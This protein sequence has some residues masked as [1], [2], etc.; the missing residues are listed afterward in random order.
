MI[1]RTVGLLGRVAGVAVVVVAVAG[2]GVAWRL[3]QGPLSLDGLTPYVE[4]ALA[5]VVPGARVEIG[6]LGLD[7][8]DD[9]DN[10][11]GRLDVRARSVR[12]VDERG[13][14]LA[15]VPELG[16]GVSVRAL[17]R[18]RLEPTRLE[19]VRP[20]IG[21][22]RRAD[23]G[24]DLGVR[25]D[26]A[27]SEATPE[28][29]SAF[30]EEVLATLLDPPDA[31]RPLGLLRQLSV[32]GADLRVINQVTGFSWHATRADIDLRRSGRGVDAALRLALDTGGEPAALAAT[33]AFDRA[34]GRTAATVRVEDLEPARLARIAPE[35]APLAGA[36]FAVDGTVDLDLD[37]TLTPQRVHFELTGGAGQVTL[38]PAAGGET[39]VV[40]S[41][42]ARGS[43]DVAARRLEIETA[44]LHLDRP[45]D[46]AGTRLTLTG[47][48]ALDGVAE[49]AVPTGSLRLGLGSGPGSAAL[50][51]DAVRG[52]ADGVDLAI[53]L[54]GLKPA[55]LAGLVPEL[56]PLAAAGMPPVSGT[57]ALRL[58]GGLRPRDG[59]VDLTLGAGR[60]VLPDHFA[61]PPE[62]RSGV[63]RLAFDAAAR[64]LDLEEATL[65]LGGP[66]VTAH[67]RA[68]P[69]APG[70]A[71][72]AVQGTVTAQA[73]PLDDLG[74]LWPAGVGA[75]AREW[76]TENLSRGT[77]HEAQAVIAGT[78]PADDPAGFVLDSLNAGLTASD[79]DIAYFRPMPPVVG[80]AEVRAESDGR[81]FTV[82]TRGG[83]LEDVEVGEG[84]IVIN[85]LGGRE[86]IDIRVPVS[87]PV[88]TILTVLDGPPLGYPS[89]LDID[90]AG[91]AG[92]ARADLTF[93]FPLLQD[94]TFDDVEVGVDAKLTGTA[95]RKVAAGLDASDGTLDLVLDTRS[96]SV[97]GKAR[98][99]GV[100]VVLDWKEQFEDTAK[101]PRTRVHVRGTADATDFAKFGVEAAEY[102]AGPVGTDVVFTID[103]NKRFSLTGTLDLTPA[104]LVL[105]DFGWSKAPGVPASARF[106]LEFRKDKVARVTGIAYEGG[107][108]SAT[109]TVTLDPDTAALT[110]VLLEEVRLDETA[111]RADVLVRDGG[112]V[113]TVTGRS[114]DAR[115]F[116]EDEPA[117]APGAAAGGA[118]APPRRRRSLDLSVRVGRVV[119]GEGRQLTDVVAKARNDGLDWTLIDAT[120]S[121]GPSSTLSI[122]FEPDGDRFRVL[123]LSN[124]AGRA[125]RMLD[126]NDRVEGGTLRITGTTRGPRADAPI[127]GR[128]EMTDYTVVEAPTL[129]RILNAVSP[130][131]FAELMQG[132]GIT[133]GRLEGEFRKQGRLL[134]LSGVRTSGSALGLTLEGEVDTVADVANLRGTIVPVYGLNRIVGQI[135]ILGDVL[136]GGAGQGIF[137]A[138][139]HVQGPFADPKVSVNPLAVLAPGFLRNLFF[140]GQGGD[141]EPAGPRRP[142]SES[143]RN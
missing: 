15:A 13:A 41:S 84:T 139:W 60:L 79:V 51:M 104:V 67:G 70:G 36:A 46:G 42:G 85:N 66:S 21:V 31:G 112:Y 12:A 80:V 40:R 143:N 117:A 121:S 76:I 8:V 115:R 27:A 91:T 137:A 58:D 6:S 10:G 136:S 95:V 92:H 129:A 126:L 17:L 44:A 134:T 48:V 26:A 55:L 116:L 140:L 132:R 123:V 57:A 16:V 7:W 52:A 64:T 141:P 135:P 105:E 102:A 125:L 74:R 54:E 4:D 32:T 131:G 9:D 122:R 77:V 114:L 86:D 89:R 33:A 108:L 11:I 88:R 37:A 5:G 98:L 63:L 99:D 39:L 61:E 113:A 22:V 106:A 23:G 2:G 103:R 28:G 3:S 34:T 96:M 47:G 35:L 49:G 45:G 142:H 62:L 100:P 24:F 78:L 69:A 127:E 124:D 53:R 38:P 75:A 50:V 97:K 109:G 93:R 68:V 83:R 82:H 43:L 120:G 110:H 107:G 56:E 29:T 72:L 119:F 128:I 130:T 73:V 20:R 65:D 30:A 111:V 59:R 81:T 133:F 138:T 118:A 25:S 94:L 19:L 87:G 71:A 90:P 101:G 1:R 14:E 18:A